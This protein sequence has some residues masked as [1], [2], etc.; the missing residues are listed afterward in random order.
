MESYK[1]KDEKI[2]IFQ[3]KYLFTFFKGS[4]KKITKEIK[5]SDSPILI[6]KKTFLG[7]E[8]PILYN[9]IT[10]CHIPFEKLLI[11]L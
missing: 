9:S 5:A 2:K 7:S 4:L 1:Q 11:L 8:Q 10:T 3:I 6:A